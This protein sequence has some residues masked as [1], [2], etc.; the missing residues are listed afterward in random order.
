MKRFKINLDRANVSTSIDMAESL[1]DAK[2]EGVGWGEAAAELVAEKA[3]ERYQV[4]I[5]AA[6]ARYGVDFEPG[7]KI[8]LQTLLT[9]IEGKTGLSIQTLTPD[10]VL[11]AVD[12]R[13]SGRMSELLG[14]DVGSLIDVDALKQKLIDEAAKAITSG[15]ATKLISKALIKRLRRVKTYKAGGLDT[16]LERKRVLNR[17]NQKY[18]RRTHKEVWVGSPGDNGQDWGDDMHQHRRDL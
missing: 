12:D 3:V 18:Y 16:E 6:F 4:G 7:E 2:K 13:V 14:F 1:W 9:A 17:A 11:S 8:T 5:A 15:R 10:G